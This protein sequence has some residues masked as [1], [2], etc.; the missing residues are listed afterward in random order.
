MVSGDGMRLKPRLSHPPAPGTYPPVPTPAGDREKL[1]RVADREKLWG[2]GR[3]I[4]AESGER[5]YHARASR[6]DGAER[7]GIGSR[8]RDCRED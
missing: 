4:V 8:Y 5:E 6:E 3:A 2:W 1:S 7:G